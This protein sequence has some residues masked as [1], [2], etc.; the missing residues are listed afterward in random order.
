[1]QLFRG[2]SCGRWQRPRAQHRGVL[3][4]T[5]R[6]QRLAWPMRD[7]DCAAVVCG[8]LETAGRSFSQADVQAA[9]LVFEFLKAMRGHE[10]EQALELVEIHAGHRKAGSRALSYS[11][12][13]LRIPSSEGQ[14]S[15]S[16]RGAL[17]KTS[18]PSA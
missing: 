15:R 13:C 11:W 2:R 7:P 9:M 1:M 4:P 8:A 16:P 10:V 3:R 12:I 18:V 5:P 14:S 17:V 6:A